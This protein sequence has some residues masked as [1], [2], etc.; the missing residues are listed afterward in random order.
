MARH[1]P[2]PEEGPEE[3][4]R[5][6]KGPETA[7]ELPSFDLHGDPTTTYPDVDSD[8]GFDAPC[9]DAPAGEHGDAG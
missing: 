3:K 1:D 6:R 9:D 2:F 7:R 4:R 5:I 8:D